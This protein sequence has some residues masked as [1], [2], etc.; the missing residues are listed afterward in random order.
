MS[1]RSAV[2]VIVSDGWD[3]ADTAELLPGQIAHLHRLAGKV[4]WAD[5]LKIGPGYEPMFELRQCLRHV[6]AHVPARDFA[7][8]M[9]VARLVR[10]I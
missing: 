10:T 3:S 8:L 5:P 7:A 9:S 1:T 6:D 4:I 2:A